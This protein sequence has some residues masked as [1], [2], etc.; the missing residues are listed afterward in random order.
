MSAIGKAARVQYRSALTASTTWCAAMSLDWSSPESLD[1]LLVFRS[2]RAYLLGQKVNCGTM[3]LAALQHF[4]P[5]SDPRLPGPLGRFRRSLQ[6]WNKLSPMRQRLPFPW[7]ALMAVIGVLLEEKDVLAA[8]YLFIAFITYLR[9]GEIARLR[10]NQLVPP[11]LHLGPGAATWGVLLSP[12]SLGVP[13]KTGHYDESVVLDNHSWLHP[14]LLMMVANRPPTDLLFPL[15]PGWI[16]ARFSEV[17]VRLGLGPLQPC[18]YG[19]RHGGASYDLLMRHRSV[20]EVK[21][22]GRW[23]SDQSLRRYGKESRVMQE[24]NKLPKATLLFG[25]HIEAELVTVFH[26]APSMASPAPVSG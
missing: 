20:A 8:L 21:K 4:L 19:L 13:G 17:C 12:A 5:A 7:V 18:L 1:E 11:A 26:A 23:A 15:E 10:V 25:L 6:G 24:A 14:F 9:P 2:D 3:L 22:R 16:R